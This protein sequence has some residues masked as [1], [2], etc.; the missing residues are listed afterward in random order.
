MQTKNKIKYSS[1]LIL[2]MIG[3]EA[4]KLGTA[5]YI[6]KFTNSFWLVSILYLL[7][8][9]PTFISYLLNYK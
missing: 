1:S 2:S 7:I 6:Y 4:F 3:S 5:I 8:Q 9:I